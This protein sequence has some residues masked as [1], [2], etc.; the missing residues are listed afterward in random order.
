MKQAEAINRNSE[1]LQRLKQQLQQKIDR[2]VEKHLEQ[3][4]KHYRQDQFAEAIDE[5]NQVLKMEPNNKQAQINMLR[6]EQ[7]LSNL[8]RLIEK[9]E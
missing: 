2:A 7:V 6:A 3:G 1:K 8:E 4:I 5:W 9:R